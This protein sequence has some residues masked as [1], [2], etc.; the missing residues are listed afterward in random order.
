MSEFA[1]EKQEEATRTILESYPE[2]VGCGGRA[3]KTNNTLCKS[4]WND[5]ECFEE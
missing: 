3:I 2:C 1:L 4:C 5:A